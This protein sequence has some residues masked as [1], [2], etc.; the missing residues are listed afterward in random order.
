MVMAN[1]TGIHTQERPAR[2]LCGVCRTGLCLACLPDHSCFVAAAMAREPVI[3]S[4]RRIWRGGDAQKV[5]HRERACAVNHG[6]LV[7]QVADNTCRAVGT[8]RER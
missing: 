1:C 3:V 7:A 5:M 2:T 8:K 4:T 6:S